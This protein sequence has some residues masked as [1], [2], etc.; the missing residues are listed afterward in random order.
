MIL[1]HEVIKG[2]GEIFVTKVRKQAKTF[3]SEGIY[4]SLIQCLAMEC[5]PIVRKNII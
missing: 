5:L 3:R 1:I 4:E 2:E